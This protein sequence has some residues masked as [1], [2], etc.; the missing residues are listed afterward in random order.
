MKSFSYNKEERKN[1]DED[2]RRN[3]VHRQSLANEYICPSKTK[4]PTEYK[5]MSKIME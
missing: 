1:R 4:K 2:I 5:V 3:E